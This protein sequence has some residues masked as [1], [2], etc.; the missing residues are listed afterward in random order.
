MGRPVRG[1]E[2]K[3]VDSQGHDLLDGE[4]GE[5]L[6]RGEGM[7]HG[8]WNNP[9][10]TAEKFAGGWLHTGDLVIHDEAGYFRLVGR[11]KDMIRRTGENIAA[12]EVEAVLGE[13]PGVRAAAVV[14]VPD[15]LRGEEVKAF[16]Q[17]QPGHTPATAPPEAILGFVRSRL[18]A[19]KVPRFLEYIE[20][21]PLTPSERIAKHELLRATGDQRARAYDAVTRQWGRE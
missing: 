18:A 14:P 13:H 8:Y 20:R 21:F 10:A 7:M 17:L 12:A 1:R 6:L 5:L 19:F 16:V 4:V 9:A 2:A 15:E 3:V 11:T